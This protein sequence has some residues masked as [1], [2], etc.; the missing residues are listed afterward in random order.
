MN[1]GSWKV[2]IVALLL[3]FAVACGND[4]GTKGGA[5]TSPSPTAEPSSEATNSGSGDETQE[6]EKPADS[7]VD[8]SKLNELLAQFESPSPS[9][10]VTLSVAITELFDA[11]GVAPVGVPTSSSTLPAAFDSVPRVG[12]SHQPDVEAIAGLQPD[13]ILGPASIK[14]NLEKQFEAAKLPTGYLPADSL[15][16]LKLSLSALGRL[17]QKEDAAKAYIEKFNGDEQAA[18]ATV[19]GKEAPSVLILFGSVESLMFMNENTFVGSLVKNLGGVNVVSDVLKLTETYTPLDMESIVEANPDMILLV[20]HGDPNAV[21]K[22]F[23]EDVKSSGAWEKLSAFQ[24]GKLKALDYR[25][26]GIA[27]LPKAVSAYN[28]LAGI[29]YE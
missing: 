9:K 5:S 12:S 25:L 16:E 24:N 7:L 2:G 28:E 19:E 15:D 1:Y 8:E 27:S 17:F 29:M 23:E 14:E 6:T 3:A 21:S 22:K 18:I 20:A 4:T 13:V 11:I 10:A 26:F